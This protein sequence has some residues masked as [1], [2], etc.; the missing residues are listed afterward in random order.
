MK[1][2]VPRNGWSPAG[3]S[4]LAMLAL[5][6]CGAESAQLRTLP[7]Q[8]PAEENARAAES[9]AAFAAAAATAD[10]GAAAGDSGAGAADSGAG[11]GDSAAGAARSPAGGEERAPPLT[12][13]EAPSMRTY[14]PWERL[15]R[16]TYRF[17]A[18]FDEAVF[19]PVANAYRR[20]PSPLRAGVHN[21]FGNLYEVDSMLNYAL[22]GRFA[23]G[24]RSIGRF[25]V[26]STAGIAGLFDVARRMK[27]PPAPTGWGN[28][29]AVWGVHPGPY[30]VIPLLGPSTLRDGV[31]FVADY[32]TSYAVNVAGLYR[33][34]ASWGL[35]LLNAVDQRAQINFRYYGSGS[36]F[37]YENVRFLYVRKTLIEDDAQ[38]IWRTTR[39]DPQLP[40]GQ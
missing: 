5:A 7:P 37:E 13:E 18:R 21:F 8:N 16:L 10:S 36:P 15:N 20:A 9:A 14:D 2:A 27:L 38:R 28:T 24:A 4:A 25:V 39:P 33:G 22:Q 34:N 26:N 12:A 6:G 17:N 29:L 35:T 31:G 30:W 40:A 19:L 11:A 3:L 23:L 32:G 1:A